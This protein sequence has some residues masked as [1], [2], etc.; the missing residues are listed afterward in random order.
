MDYILDKV[1]RV[2]AFG[3]PPIAKIDDGYL[4][5]TD[6]DENYCNILALLGLPNSIV[7]GYVQPWVSQN[8][9]FD[10]KRMKKT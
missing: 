4:D 7:Y 5:I 1:L 10:Q 2:F 8:H 3:S 6:N 9:S